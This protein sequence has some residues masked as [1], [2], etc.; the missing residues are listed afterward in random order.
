M[1]EYQKLMREISALGYPSEYRIS[2]ERWRT[3]QT[4]DTGL[5]HEV[6]PGK[7]DILGVNLVIV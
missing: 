5:F 4:E 1:K 6:E 3:I 7:P 2:V